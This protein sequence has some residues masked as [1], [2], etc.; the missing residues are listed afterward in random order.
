[1]EE[2]FGFK[3]FDKDLKC[4]DT[5]FEIGKIY[6]INE[7]PKLC[8]R[9]FHFGRSLIQAMRW[10]PN[11]DGNRYCEVRATGETEY[12]DDKIVTN[13][14]EI[15]KELN[16]EDICAVLDGINLSLIKNAITNGG[17]ICGSLALKLQGFDLGRP[18]KDIDFIFKDSSLVDNV[19]KSY[20][21]AQTGSW[22]IENK[23]VK[24]RRAF[25]DKDY[26]MTYDI[27]IKDDSFKEVDYYGV[28][29]KVADPLK[30]WKEKLIYA[31]GGNQK[32]AKDFNKFS[33]KIEYFLTVK[34]K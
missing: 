12:S 28:K 1:M 8:Q 25:Y 7:T 22:I 14:I 9:G 5:Q 16:N 6:E 33:H 4:R 11:K 32:H 3:G 13:R 2:I 10:Y 26:N 34:E 19:F 18:I 20:S 15:I 24:G 27:F 17:I 23:S 31:F 30:I 29:V 21:L